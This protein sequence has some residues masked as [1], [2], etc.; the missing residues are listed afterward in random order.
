MGTLEA[1]V[2][3]ALTPRPVLVVLVVTRVAAL[4]V[5]GGSTE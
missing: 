1:V 3:A 2:V 5:P 4:G